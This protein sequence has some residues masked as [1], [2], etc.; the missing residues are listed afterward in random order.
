MRNHE[1]LIPEVIR[2]NGL[3]EDHKCVVCLVKKVFAWKAAVFNN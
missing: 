2:R 3:C 1:D